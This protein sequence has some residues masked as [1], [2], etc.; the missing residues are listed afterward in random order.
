MHPSPTAPSAPPLPQDASPLPPESERP[1]R[2][3]LKIQSVPKDYLTRPLEEWEKPKPK[4]WQQNPFFFYGTLKDPQTLSRI[5]DKPVSPSSLRP[6]Y[7]E[8]YSIEMWGQYKA[9]VTGPQGNIIEGMVY[10]V[11]SEEDEEK[12]TLYETSAYEVASCIIHLPAEKREEQEQKEPAEVRGKTFRYAGD[13]QALREGRW[14]PELFLKNMRSSARS[15]PGDRELR[16]VAARL[17]ASHQ[18]Q[19]MES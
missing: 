1:S 7:I 3:L 12:L 17:T 11:Q 15:H 2:F 9:L 6:A 5:L 18:S 4:I 14:D 10:E 16:D 19:E 13:A 8:G